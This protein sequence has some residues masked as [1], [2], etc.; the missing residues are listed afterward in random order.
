MINQL[1]PK[2]TEYTNEIKPKVKS[3][4]HKLYFKSSIIDISKKL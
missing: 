3:N 2:N 4:S 1:P